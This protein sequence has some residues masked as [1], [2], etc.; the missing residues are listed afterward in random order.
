MV[1]SEVLMSTILVYHLRLHSDFS[2]KI[3]LQL[4]HAIEGI[5]HKNRLDS[6]L[7][8]RPLL[9]DEDHSG[10]DPNLLSGFF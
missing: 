5:C 4:F 10:N 9:Q 7:M 8:R 3:I 2:Q 6:N 1:S